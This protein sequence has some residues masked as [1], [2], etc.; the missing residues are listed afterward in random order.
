VSVQDIKNA[1]NGQ[2]PAGQSSQMTKR[3][4]EAHKALDEID[5]V[6]EGFAAQHKSG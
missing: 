2:K 3:F 1:L 5:R 6:A 4:E